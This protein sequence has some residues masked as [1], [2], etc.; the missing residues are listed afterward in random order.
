MAD[1]AGRQRALILEP[2][3]REA[4]G[5]KPSRPRRSRVSAAPPIADVELDRLLADFELTR[6]A[7]HLLR[8]AHFRAE[9]IFS[10]QAGHL[11]LTPRQKALLIAAYRHPDANQSELAAMIAIDAN[12]LAEMVS[13][14]V[15]DGLLERSR[16]PRD[17]RAKRLRV[18][19]LAIDRLK[20]LMPLDV[21]VERQVLAPVSAARRTILVDCLRQMLQ[22]DNPSP[23]D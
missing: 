22:I 4:A 18:T 16:D 10:S 20:L 8:R 14:M 21:E 1:T 2:A 17:G 19:A 6:I 23:D 9:E 12:T 7:S 3:P 11:G 13:R 5:A 15:R